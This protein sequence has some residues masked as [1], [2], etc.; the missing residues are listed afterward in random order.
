MS[1][2]LKEL[3]FRIR[4][5]A[6]EI[7]ENTRVNTKVTTGTS[8]NSATLNNIVRL[9]ISG[10]GWLDLSS[11]NVFAKITT[12]AT[13][14]VLTPDPATTSTC[15]RKPSTGGYCSQFRILSGGGSVVED[16]RVADLYYEL[17]NRISSDCEYQ[18]N[19]LDI[20]TNGHSNPANRRDLSG[21]VTLRVATTDIS[22]FLNSTGKY[23]YLPSFGGSITLE[24]TLRS[25]ASAYVVRDGADAVTYAWTNTECRFDT[26]QVS[27]A[28]Q[29]VYNEVFREGFAMV[30]PTYSV[31][32]NNITSL[33][34]AVLQLNKRADRIRDII[35]VVRD[36]AQLNSKQVDEH[37]FLG[38]SGDPSVSYL[39]AGKRYP[40]APLDS[41]AHLYQE[42]LKCT[43]NQKNVKHAPCVNSA[44]FCEASDGSANIG[45]TQGALLNQP[46]F[47]LATELEQVPGE[48]YSGVSSSGVGDM[49]EMSMTPHA[50][51]TG[52]YRCDT[53]I[54]HIRVLSVSP[55]GVQVND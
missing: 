46:S 1:G 48:F 43:F 24:F 32:T 2:V 17:M 36:Q 26:V 50:S 34:N 23:I 4:A 30:F 8:T 40:P 45:T 31:N 19:T 49:C 39:I 12:T 5:P 15:V 14:S 11:V 29:R 55:D 28:Y 20:T 18:N 22:G 3:D 25:D 35:T 10:N 6:D 38:S 13:N 44:N 41:H 21:G 42:L 51:A 47:C 54:N 53:F 9:Q 7:L 16:M 33:S 27:E 52:P 37:H